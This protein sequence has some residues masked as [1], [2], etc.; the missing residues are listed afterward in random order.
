MITK[1]KKYM[2]KYHMADPGDEIVVGL[3]GGADS[4]C[5]LFLLQKLSGQMGFDLRAVHINHKLREEADAEEAFVKELCQKWGICC[6]STDVDVKRYGAKHHLC[7]EEAARSLRYQVFEKMAAQ[8][9]RNRKIKIALAHHKNDQAETVLFHLFRGSGIRGLMGIRPVR[10]FYIR[11]F[12]CLERREIEQFAKEHQLDFVTD[13]SNFDT[14]FSR[15]KIRHDLLPMAERE[16]CQGSI[17]HIAGTAEQ[18]ADA[19]DFLDQIV[20]QTYAGLVREQKE[21]YFVSKDDLLRLHPYLRSAIVYEMLSGICNRK[22]DISRVHVDSVLRLLEGQSGKKADLIYGMQAV[23]QQQELVV[24]KES[25]H[26][27]KG[28]REEKILDLKGEIRTITEKAEEITIR[29]RVFSYE[30][31][32]P[33]PN[34]PYTKW[35]DYDKINCC[36]VIRT[37]REG[38]YLYCSFTARK[39]IKDYFINEKIPLLE[40]DSIMMIADGNHIIWIPGYRISSFYKITDETRQVL[41]ITIS[42]GKKYE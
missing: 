21:G 9:G 25:E 15:N 41:E 18:A 28:R 35:F 2:E 29:C 42:G 23:I 10:D 4:V 37:R 27:E 20:K 3:S 5:L 8:G 1:V 19:V 14:A 11:P 36:P 12:L 33:I 26:G 24:R 38:D 7:M 40:R 39:K 34:K 17:S 13:Q 31:A 6:E 32:Q 16:I 22:R 30:K